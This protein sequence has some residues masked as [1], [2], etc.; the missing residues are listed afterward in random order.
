MPNHFAEHVF[1]AVLVVG[2]QHITVEESEPGAFSQLHDHTERELVLY[3]ALP[4]VWRDQPRL[5]L[6]RTPP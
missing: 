6:T 2:Q 5:T 4:G 1:G 3:D